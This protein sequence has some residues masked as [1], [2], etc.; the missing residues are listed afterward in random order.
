MSVFQVFYVILCL[1][2]MMTCGLKREKFEVSNNAMCGVI[3]QVPENVE[4]MYFKF[5]TKCGF[6]TYHA[7]NKWNLLND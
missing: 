4:M 1:K 2:I 7:G 3:Y 6:R 5:Y